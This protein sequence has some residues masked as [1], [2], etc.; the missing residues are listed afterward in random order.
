MIDATVTGYSGD[1]LIASVPR[2]AACARCLDGGGCG[3]GLLGRRAEGA[4]TL[5][6]PSPR[7]R[8]AGGSNVRLAARPGVLG[9][10]LVGYGLP[11]AG[12]LAGALSGPLAAAAGLAAGVLGARLVARD[13]VRWRVIVP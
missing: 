6:L 8:P 4:V 7:P 13:R 2:R 3:M 12:V 9:A 5:T 1:R 10:A 11:L